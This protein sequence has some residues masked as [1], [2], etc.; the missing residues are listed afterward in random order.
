MNTS[1]LTTAAWA[2]VWNDLDDVSAEAGDLQHFART[3]LP[4]Y[5][6]RC[7]VWSR[8]YRTAH[9]EAASSPTHPA[10]DESP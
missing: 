6:A 4:A 10:D 2:F 3:H 1:A 8:T 9:Q 5:A 7:A